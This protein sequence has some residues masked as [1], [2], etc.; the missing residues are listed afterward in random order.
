M[1]RLR[2]DARLL[3]DRITD[4]LFTPWSAYP[5]IALFWRPRLQIIRDWFLAEEEIRRS[6]SVTSHVELTGQLRLDLPA[7]PVVV[8]ARADRI[9][10]WPDG[11]VEIIDYK[12]GQPPTAT[13]VREGRATQLL[14]ETILV[15]EGGFAPEIST[16][17]DIAALSYWRLAGRPDLPVERTIVTGDKIDVAESA[18]QLRALIM[19][20]Q[21]EEMAY[22]VE[23]H[24]AA[25][26]RF[27]DTR[28]LARVKEWRLQEVDDD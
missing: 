27:S 12:T 23:P 25:R 5:Q 14:I 4:R 20:Y 26:A 7:G 6:Q 3:F 9:D 11:Q 8:Q 2:S 17:S 16:P 19:A 24:P 1:V 18:A 13:K 28:H 21:D 15:Q 10:I 22:L